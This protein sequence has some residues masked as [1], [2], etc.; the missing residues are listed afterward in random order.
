M[1]VGRFD[2]WFHHQIGR[3]RCAWEVWLGPPWLNPWLALRPPIRLTHWR[4]LNSLR[5]Q[6][7]GRQT[8]LRSVMLAD[9]LQVESTAAC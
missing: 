4:P 6:C 3:T 8:R 7:G 2:I 9:V 1:L 5:M